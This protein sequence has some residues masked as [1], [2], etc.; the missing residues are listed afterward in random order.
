M[1]NIAN[2]TVTH[3]MT[4]THPAVRLADTTIRLQEQQRSKG[5][6]PPR[7]RRSKKLQKNSPDLPAPFKTFTRL[8]CPAQRWFP[9]ADH[10]IFTHRA[11]LFTV[12]NFTLLTKASFARYL[13]RWMYDTKAASQAQQFHKVQTSGTYSHF[14]RTTDARRV[15]ISSSELQRLLSGH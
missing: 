8:I 3:S 4:N 9:S 12:E 6:S 15:T 13:Y 10:R 14:Q 1:Q 11:T 2:E 7:L 5:K